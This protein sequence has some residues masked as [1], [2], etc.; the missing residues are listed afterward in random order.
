MCVASV[1][2]LVDFH[3]LILFLFH[4]H[5]YFS[6]FVSVIVIMLSK[7]TVFKIGYIFK[8]SFT[9]ILEFQVCLIDLFFL[10]PERFF[11]LIQFAVNNT[12]Q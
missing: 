9:V 2:F 5:M 6:N 10:S 3:I 12:C 1:A 8:M 7:Y 4:I 11:D